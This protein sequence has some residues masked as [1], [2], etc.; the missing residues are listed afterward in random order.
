MLDQLILE[1]SN[2]ISFTSAELDNITASSNHLRGIV[3]NQSDFN[4]S[5]LGGSS[6]RG[7]MVKGISDVDVYFQYT[8]LGDPATALGRLKT[9][10]N[11]SFPNSDIKRDKPSIHV[12][13]DRIPFNITPYKK[14]A[15]PNRMNIPDDYLTFW[16]EVNFGELE[17]GVAALKNKNA[18]F[19]DLIKILKVWNANYNRGLKNFEIERKICNLFLYGYASQTLTDWLWTFFSNNSFIND[20]N[21]MHALMHISDEAKLKNEWQRFIE[22]K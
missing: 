13:F 12:G 5:F 18:K 22:N 6:R 3:K 8:G 20:A 21:R 9:C 11:N 1:K 16:R 15:L 19:I 14:S 17:V 7:T 10:L 4:E 2:Q